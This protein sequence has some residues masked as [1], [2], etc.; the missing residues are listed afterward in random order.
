M[1][2]TRPLDPN[3]PRPPRPQEAIPS[4][5]KYNHG[6][7]RTWGFGTRGTRGGGSTA[8]RWPSETALEGPA[9]HASMGV[10]ESVEHLGSKT[11]MDPWI[12]SCIY[13]EH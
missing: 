12:A 4:P 11:R 13:S 8:D 1:P 2:K 5:G 7:I 9:V 6:Y 3:T 10:A